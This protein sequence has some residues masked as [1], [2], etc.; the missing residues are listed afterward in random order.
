MGDIMK[1]LKIFTIGGLGYGLL[2]ILWRGYTHI[3]MILTGGICFLGIIYICRFFKNLS[4]FNKALLCALFITA[5]ESLVGFIVNIKLRLNVWDYSELP[6][7]IG[8]QVC[9]LFS[10]FWFLLS[11]VLIIFIEHINNMKHIN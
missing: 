7:N 5:A 9:A 1:I 6:F 10:F 4:L 11:L 8:G 3:S 2:E